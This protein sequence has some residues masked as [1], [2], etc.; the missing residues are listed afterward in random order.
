RI[1][2]ADMRMQVSHDG[3]QTFRP[4]KE[5]HKHS[6]NHTLT[7]RRDDPNYL[8][9]GTDGGLYESFDN[10]NNWRFVA[11]LP[12]TQ[13]YKLAVDDA[14]PFYN[15]YGGTQDNNTQAGP[16]RTDNA[17]GIRNADWYITLFADGH[18]PATEPG[19]PD[20]V[21][22]EW[23]EGNLVRVDVTTGEVIHIQPQPDKGEPHERYNWD[24][25]ILVSP[26]A[27]TRLYFASQRVWQSDDRGDS[28]KALSE[29]LT[30]DQERLTLPIM[31]ATQSWDNAW[32]VYAMSNY[33]TITSLAESPLQQGLIYA[34]TDDGLI[35]VTENSGEEWRKIEV[36]ELPDVPATAFVND[37]KTDLFDTSTV[38]IALDNHKYGDFTPYLLKSTDKGNSWQSIRGNLPDSSMVWRFVQDHEKAE[39]CFAATEFGIYFTLD[40]GQKWMQLKGNVPTISFRDLAIQRREND[41]IGASFGRGFYLLDNYSFLREVTPEQLAREATLF[42]PAKAWWYIPRSRLGLSEKGAMGADHFAAPN[43]PFGAVFNYYL[44]EGYSSLKQQRQKEEKE[45]LKANTAVE[46]PGWEKLNE[47]MQQDSMIVWVIIK[48]QSGDVVR[49]VKGP[50]SK[51]FHQLAWD[52]RYPVTSAMSLHPPKYNEWYKPQGLLAPPGLY[53]ATLAKQENGNLTLLSKQLSF[54]VVPLR[55]GALERPD[56]SQSA[57]F[58]RKTEQF[59]RDLTAV[60]LALSKARQKTRVMNEA[61]NR[62][63]VQPGSMIQEL[64]QIRQE[65]YDLHIRLNGPAAQKEVG[66]KY[67]P[68]VKDRFQI[69]MM[70]IRNSTYGPTATHVRNLEIAVEELTLINTQLK[71]I[72]EDK[73]PHLEQIL[74]ENGAPW[75]EGMKL[76]PLE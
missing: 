3:G 41:L 16:S 28:W 52:L 70:G 19:N 14:E 58:W 6:D 71:E 26:H 37:I 8:L 72:L 24:A 33:N 11:N 49:R 12:V 54:E 34:G 23:Q 56:I 5:R 9:V 1:Y 60:S 29:D 25:P 67:P 22:N 7:F 17:H 38:Y 10:A 39:L 27:P 63:E 47:E 51:G 48:D 15:I 74:L 30:R 64:Y 45:M 65:L 40:G 31:G 68:T 13:F 57:F 35:Q 62:S 76:P 46:F 32:D 4:M 53:T 75:V 59:Q 66:E 61:L 20:I 42:Q 69:V 44:A 55:S 43:P 18:Q 36:S 2:L 73:L 21:Y 50:I